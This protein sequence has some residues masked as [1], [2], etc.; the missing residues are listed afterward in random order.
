M[1][2]RVNVRAPTKVPITSAV[3]CR[4]KLSL[5]EPSNVRT[6]IE[7]E[8]LN[9][10]SKFNGKTTCDKSVQGL[11]STSGGYNTNK[12]LRVAP[13]T[14]NPR[15]VT[16][17]NQNR[18]GEVWNTFTPPV[19]FVLCWPLFYSGGTTAPRASR[20]RSCEALPTARA[21]DLRSYRGTAVRTSCP[22]VADLLLAREAFD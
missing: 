22:F 1:V 18:T 3:S 8:K 16:P 6:T 15:S 5:Y 11:Y 17:K 21:G 4:D 13:P 14:T 9:H 19:N 20:E 7:D 2:R 12:D 10:A